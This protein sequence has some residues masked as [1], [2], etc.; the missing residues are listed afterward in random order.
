MNQIKKG[1]ILYE[2]EDTIVIYEKYQ[3]YFDV[4]DQNK[5]F[6]KYVISKEPSLD[7]IADIEDYYVKVKE[8]KK[9]YEYFVD[10]VAR[11]V[12]DNLSQEYKNFIFSH[13]NPTEHHFGLG[14][15]IRNKYIHGKQLD[16]RYVHPDSLS[17]EIL[18]RI[19]S[20]IIGSY[21]EK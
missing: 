10:W 3:D 6:V 15:A 11:D 16:F 14:L 19:A 13:P 20:M 1:T 18:D 8:E 7:L 5:C 4:D 9:K 17:T 12:L 21:N 2:N